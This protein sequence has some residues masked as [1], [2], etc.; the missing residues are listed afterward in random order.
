MGLP[1]KV[2]IFVL[3]G[4][5]VSNVVEPSHC[6]TWMWFNVSSGECE[7]GEL[8]MDAI[9]C[10]KVNTSGIVFAMIDYCIS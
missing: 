4:S 1:L 7:C 5:R 6:S 2:L 9:Q 3:L 8:V 10:N